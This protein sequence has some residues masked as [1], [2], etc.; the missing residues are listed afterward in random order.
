MLLL[1]KFCVLERDFTKVSSIITIKYI[2]PQEQ[3]I[4]E[5]RM[6]K[7]GHCDSMAQLKENF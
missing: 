2:K 7:I 5:K 6:L 3:W 4:L 1:R